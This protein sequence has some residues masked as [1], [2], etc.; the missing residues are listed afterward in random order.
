MGRIIVRCVGG[1]GNRVLSLACGLLAAEKFSCDFAYCWPLYFPEKRRGAKDCMPC[2]LDELWDNDL[3]EVS[4]EE[5]EALEQDPK[6]QVHATGWRKE[7][8]EFPEPKTDVM[9]LWGHGPFPIERK[10][11][12]QLTLGSDLSLGTSTWLQSM[13]TQLQQRLAF[14]T[15]KYSTMV[16][17]FAD[18]H[19]TGRT[20]TAL[21]L[22]AKGVHLLRRGFDPVARF[23]T[24]SRQLLAQKPKQL[25]YLSC[26]DQKIVRQFRQEFGQSVAAVTKPLDVNTREALA[27]SVAE[28]RLLM[29]ADD[30]YGTLGSGWSNLA[31]FLREGS[32]V[33]AD[34]GRLF[35][36]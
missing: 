24:F 33:H 21:Q 16:D 23:Q 7:H 28:L 19:F 20:V 10:D 12:G 4:E 9:V 31:W 34:V 22:R 5:R 11:T 27:V 17:K 1:L 8:R 2:T 29:R 14:K 36:R 26:D 6:T 13:A 30:Y 32:H 25:L 35:M 18:E 3:T 15:D